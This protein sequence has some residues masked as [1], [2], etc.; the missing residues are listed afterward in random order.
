MLFLDNLVDGDTLLNLGDA[1][2][3]E[4]IPQL[5]LRLKFTKAHRSL[6]SENET[7]FVL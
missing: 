6:V 7:M 5:G 3:K 1:E 2:T 4:L